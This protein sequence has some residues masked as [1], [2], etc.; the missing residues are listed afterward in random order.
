[1]TEGAAHPSARAS[2]GTL[3][4]TDDRVF[5]PGGEALTRRFAQ[6]VLW[7]DEVR[8]LALD[9]SRASA[10]LTYRLVK[11]DQTF[12]M[13]R[14]ADAV[15]GGGEELEENALPRWPTGEPVT[16]HRYGDVISLLEIATFADG[17]LIAHHPAIAGNPAIAR[18]VENTLRR[19]PGVIEATATGAKTELRVRFNPAR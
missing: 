9:P 1:L 11:G 5:G 12:F 15:V 8:S 6:R 7:F 10:T 14:S 18:R 3:T 13:M 19:A 17:R 2:P 4:V 16:L